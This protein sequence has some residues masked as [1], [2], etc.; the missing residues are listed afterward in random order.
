LSLQDRP[1]NADPDWFVL[2]T[3]GVRYGLGRVA[4]PADLIQKI[5]DFGV[6]CFM[7]VLDCHLGTKWVRR[8]LMQLTISLENTVS[9]SSRDP[10]LSKT[11]RALECSERLLRIVCDLT[12]QTWRGRTSLQDLRALDKDAK[13]ALKE[14]RKAVSALKRMPAGFG[15]AI[16]SGNYHGCDIFAN[17]D[18]FLETLIRWNVEVSKAK[19]EI[20]KV[21]E[22]L[23]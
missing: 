5:K 16:T 2:E 10:E 7:S 15:G 1:S 3:E 6:E 18:S 22:I 14:L 17:L 21:L 8:I 12:H 11:V 4:M 19:D 20:V 13:D 23:D 9:R